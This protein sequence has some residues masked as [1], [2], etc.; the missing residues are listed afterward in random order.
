M[1]NRKRCGSI[2]WELYPVIKDLYLAPEAG[3]GVDDS[4][5][6]WLGK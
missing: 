2:E 3:V 4:S 1:D 6:Y 5:T